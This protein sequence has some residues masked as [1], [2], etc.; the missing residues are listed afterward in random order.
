MAQGGPSSPSPSSSSS[1]K[2]NS[3]RSSLSPVTTPPLSPST[4]DRN[5]MRSDHNRSL[6]DGGMMS[7]VWSRFRSR[8]PRPIETGPT[9]TNVIV[10]QTSNDDSAN[11]VTSPMSDHGE[12]GMMPPPMSPPLPPRSSSPTTTTTTNTAA[13]LPRHHA[14]TMPNTGSSRHPPP[15]SSPLHYISAPVVPTTAGHNTKTTTTTGES[16]S[17]GGGR[18]NR[19]RKRSSGT[20]SRVGRHGNE[21][22]LGDISFRETVRDTVDLF[23]K[24]SS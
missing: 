2:V 24:N 19:N 6:S 13:A 15:P 3:P 14:N 7:N 12:R 18:A 23:R 8:S 4:S 10:R 22:L 16:G 1:A 9:T 20:Y 17:G 21:W 5:R 11:L